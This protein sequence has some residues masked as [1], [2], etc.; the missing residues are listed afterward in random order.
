LSGGGV[1]MKQEL[2]LPVRVSGL[3]FLARAKKK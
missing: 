3:L 2:S 1:G